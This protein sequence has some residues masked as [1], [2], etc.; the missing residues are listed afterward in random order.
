MQ[1][2]VPGAEHVDD[3]ALALLAADAAL[4]NAVCQAVRMMQE[5]FDSSPIDV[6]CHIDMEDDSDPA[7]RLVVT[8]YTRESNPVAKLRKVQ[9]AWADCQLP[10][11]SLELAVEAAA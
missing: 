6:E 4:Y 5:A 8:A 10:G 9:R 2:R 11:G 7:P 3:E 1:P